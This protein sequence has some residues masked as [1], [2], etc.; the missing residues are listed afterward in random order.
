MLRKATRNFGH[1]G[2]KV[3]ATRNF[4]AIGLSPEIRNK[5]IVSSQSSPKSVRGIVDYPPISGTSESHVFLA[6]FNPS[7]ET[8]KRYDEAVE[9]WK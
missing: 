9:D 4:A 2:N 8:V 5:T 7:A 1:L 6:P 3:H